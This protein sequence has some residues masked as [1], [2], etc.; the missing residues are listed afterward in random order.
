MRLFR[1]RRLWII[2]FLTFASLLS[3]RDRFGLRFLRVG[4]RSGFFFRFLFGFT[5]R[6]FLFVE[7]IFGVRLGVFFFGNDL[8]LIGLLLWFAF[9]GG[10]VLGGFVLGDLILRGFVLGGFVFGRNVL[11]GVNLR[12]GFLCALGLIFLVRFLLL[13]LRKRV[14]LVNFL[15]F[16]FV[17]VITV[18]W[19]IFVRLKSSW[20]ML[21]PGI[22][23]IGRLLE[24]EA[25]LLLQL[26]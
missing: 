13:L 8:N 18:K 5:S 21:V 9:F 14:I 6:I 11:R 22:V 16:F 7:F 19:D 25:L 17:F 3:K 4:S 23:K 2:I 24:V 26:W 12:L 15:A 10:Y 20:G 1:E